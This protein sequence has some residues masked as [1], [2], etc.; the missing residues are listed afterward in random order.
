[1]A[2]V[3]RWNGRIAVLAEPVTI[4]IL[5]DLHYG[6]GSSIPERRSSIGDILLKRAVSRLN[7]LIHP[8]ITLVVGDL[9][10]DGTRRGAP[11]RLTHLRSILDELKTPYIAIPGNHDGDPE[12]FYRVFTSPRNVEDF[13]GARF[14]AFVD[15]EEPGFN[16]RR[17]ATD[18]ARFRMAR[19]GH[20]GPIV[21]LQH[22]CLFPPEQCA[23]P[24]NYTNA[25]EIVAA[26]RD[27]GVV[28]SVSGHHHL[29]S[30][31]TG[32][33]SITFVNAPALCEAP[34]AFLVA[35]VDGDS[36][37]T[38][39]HQLSLPENSRL[40]DS[41]LH[42]QLAYCNGNM[43]VET[44]IDLARDFGLAGVGFAEHS[45]HLYFD[46]Q[47]YCDGA[48]L[49]E[50]LAG[51]REE[52]N[53]MPDYLALKRAHA[54]GTVRFGLEVDCD[55][56]GDLL[57][58]P[59]DRAHFDYVIGALHSAPGLTAQQPPTEAVNNEFLF[60]VE[61]LLESSP[62]VLA[63]PFR[64]F[65]RSGWDA[66]AELFEPTAR[67]LRK[68]R[69]AAEIN[70]HTNEPPVEFVQRCLH[71]GVRLSFASDAHD[72]SEVGDFA[73]HL[74]LLRDAGFDGDL[75]DVLAPVGVADSETVP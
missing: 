74:A 11:E 64:V 53:R 26:M 25:A 14:L 48:C 29:G 27:T 22:V 62:V 51:A 55:H 57:L 65:R 5:A 16:A 9:L 40:V 69:T 52:D 8:D 1:M 63:H 68:Y 18:I 73:Y 3:G 20:R 59:S 50:G 17:S 43:T 32:E 6:A 4:A 19:Q 36:V 71:L 61:R 38:Q 10:D 24:Y 15:K 58:R 46:R 70:F 28:L 31:D 35:T 56:K 12:A 34:F 2:A 75:A 33:G 7:R 45:G 30:E 21:A 72:L 39:R 49:R 37:R 44:A 66:P 54:C 42:T 67:L 47:R 41:H 60:L 13:C 23:A